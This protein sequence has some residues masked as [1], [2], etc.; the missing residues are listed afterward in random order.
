MFTNRRRPCFYFILCFI[1]L[2]LFLFYCFKICIY[3][4]RF[5]HRCRPGYTMSCSARRRG[6]SCSRSCD[7]MG[8]VHSHTVPSTRRPS[9]GTQTWAQPH[10]PCG[11]GPW[12]RECPL[13]RTDRPAEAGQGRGGTIGL[14]HCWHTP[15]TQTSHSTT[16]RGRSA[17]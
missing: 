15:N 2:F 5:T 3:Y 6:S 9:R 1:C 12:A 11:I 4:L 14:S 16:R 8:S 17:W 7:R 10:N 13:T